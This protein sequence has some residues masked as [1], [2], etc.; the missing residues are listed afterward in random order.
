MLFSPKEQKK[1]YHKKVKRLSYRFGNLIS[2]W[3]AFFPADGAV[4][5]ESPLTLR[6]VRTAGPPKGWQLLRT[7]KTQH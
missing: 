1:I 4:K 6:V 7:R 3:F 5:V 2:L